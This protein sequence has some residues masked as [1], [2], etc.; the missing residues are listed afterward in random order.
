MIDA[1]AHIWG[2]EICELPWLAGSGFPAEVSLD[3][4]AGDSPVVLVTADAVGEQARREAE[5][6]SHLASTDPRVHG[7]VAGVDLRDD[8]FDWLLTLPGLVGVRHNLQDVI[9]QLPVDVMVTGMRSLSSMGIAFDACVRA[10]ELPELNR[11]L[12]QVPELRV[13]LDH[14]GKPPVGDHSAMWRWSKQVA[15]LAERP[16]TWCKL[17][18]LPAECKS[19]DQLADVAPGAIR[20]CLDA[21]GPDRC[22]IGSDRPISV[23]PAWTSRVLAEVDEPDH[24]LVLHEV[25]TTVYRRLA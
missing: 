21:F 24:Q 1:H 20:T 4:V 12:D 19:P 22:L 13:V 16:N 11:V 10:H 5:H 14:L 2:S 3:E 23:D 6:F 7:F 17:S 25:A 18:G 8:D 9:H 15:R